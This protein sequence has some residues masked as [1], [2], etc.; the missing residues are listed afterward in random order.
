[1]DKPTYISKEDLT[2]IQNAKANVAYMRV[3]AE[4]AAAERHAAELEVKNM[5]LMAFMKYGLTNNDNIDN[6]GRI[7]YYT[8]E[9]TNAEED[10]KKEV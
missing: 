8:S 3:L 4:K 5:I 1:M 10:S 2:A 9:E 6:D 7:I